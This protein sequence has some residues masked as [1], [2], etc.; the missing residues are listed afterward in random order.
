MLG[1]VWWWGPV[2]HVGIAVGWQ[3]QG[4][5]FHVGVAPQ[6]GLC[7]AGWQCW[8]LAFH[9]EVV[10]Q[11]GLCM[12][13]W[14][15]GGPCMPCWDGVMVVLAC[16]KLA[17]W[18]DL[19]HSDGVV[20]AADLHVA[21]MEAARLACSKAEGL[22]RLK[23][24]GHGG[25]DYMVERWGFEDLMCGVKRVSVTL[26]R[27]EMK[28]EKKTYLYLHACKCRKWQWQDLQGLRGKAQG[29]GLCGGEAGA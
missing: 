1:M 5:V 7:M 10:P 29:W 11:Q 19:V 22:A 17:L 13:G 27:K 18:A 16:G 23:R 25:G 28:K 21:K 4:L 3:Q 12:A 26:V 20:V 24:Q 15:H 9:V 8:G 2:C 14:Y 6:Q